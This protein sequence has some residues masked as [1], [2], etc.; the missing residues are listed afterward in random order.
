MRKALVLGLC[1]MLLA[2]AFPM[3]QADAAPTALKEEQIQQIQESLQDESKELPIGEEFRIKVQPDDLSQVDGLDEDWVN[4]L[5]LGTDTGNLKL[6]YGRTDAMLIASINAKSGKVK[7][8]SIVR[9]LYVDIPF[10][11]MQNR[12]NTANAFGGPLLAV[13]TANE[14]LGLNINRYCSVNFRGFSRIVDY[15]GGV[16]LLLAPEEAALAG[17]PASDQP[18][19][20]NGEQAL[21]YA[22]IRQTDN[23]FGR[24]ERQRK[25]LGAMLDKVKRSDFGTVMDIVFEVFRA[26]AT[27]LTTAE[28]VALLPAVLDNQD[29]LEMLSLPQDGSFSYFTTEWGAAVVKYDQ[30]ALKETF[31]SFVYGE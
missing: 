26:I 4:V 30:E 25:L 14:V 12:I 13:K 27:D 22:R 15:L 5:V 29:S 20:L 6:N 28:V 1:L 16:E 31:H 7:L 11:K 10:L 18:Q 21:A 9:D 2:S 17:A 3:A 19:L 23:N 8:T 24:N